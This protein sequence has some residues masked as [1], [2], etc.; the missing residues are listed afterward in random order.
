VIKLGGDAFRAPARTEAAACSGLFKRDMAA[1]LRADQLH[2]GPQ[3]RVRRRHRSL[4]ERPPPS[5]VA[6]GNWR[7]RPTSPADRREIVRRLRQLREGPA[8]DAHEGPLPPQTRE[9]RQGPSRTSTC[10]T[11]CRHCEHPHC[12]ADLPAQR[13]PSRPRTARCSSTRPA[14]AAAIASAIALMGRDPPWTRCRPKKPNL[15]CLAVRRLRPPGPGEAAQEVDREEGQPR[16]HRR[17]RSSCDMCSGIEGGPACVRAPARPAPRSRVRARGVPDRGPPGTRG[18][19][20][21]A[22]RGIERTDPGGGDGSSHEGFLRHKSY[23][24]LKVASLPLP[25]RDHCLHA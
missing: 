16:K 14:S 20:G 15:L 22:T 24:W 13:D 23:R 8:A 9:G 3:G 19:E 7:G 12:M 2:R 11:S 25:G 4:F 5:L 21:V 17:R 6:N 10:R 1:R 18:L